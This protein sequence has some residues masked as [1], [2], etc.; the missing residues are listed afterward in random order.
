VIGFGVGETL[1]AVT[2]H[3]SVKR[4]DLAD[5]STGVLDHAVYFRDTNKDAIKNP[6]VTVYVNDG[7]Q[8][9]RMQPEATYDVIAL[10]PPPITHAGVGA[11]YSTEFYQLARTRL[12]P[13]GYISQWLPAYQTPPDITL[14]MVRAFLD[15]FPQAV[16]LSGADAELLL[17]GV[18]GHESKS[19]R[20]ALY[21]GW[22]IRRPLRRTL[23]ASTWEPCANWWA[24]LSAARTPSTMR[25]GASRR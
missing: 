11:L 18:N 14:A 10:E 8:H 15:A 17:I 16:L 19:I 24:H 2:L 21:P 7:R 23:R 4:V 25:R 9:L 12:K 20:L 13:G 1:H 5:L 22:P 3:P 6:R